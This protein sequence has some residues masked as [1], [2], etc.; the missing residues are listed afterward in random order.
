MTL[1]GNK[2][3]PSFMTI[4]GFI[5]QMLSRISFAAAMGDTGTSTILTRVHVIMISSPN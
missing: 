4:Q 1:A 3:P 2:T 5:L